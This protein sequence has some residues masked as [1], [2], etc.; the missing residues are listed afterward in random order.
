[1]SKSSRLR[2]GPA[3]SDSQVS[4]GKQEAV[5]NKPQVAFSPN[6]ARKFEALVSSNLI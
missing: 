4:A 1:M 2:M 5:S 6:L 3:F